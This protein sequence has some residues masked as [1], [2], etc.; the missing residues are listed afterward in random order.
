M[1]T[2]NWGFLF[3]LVILTLIGFTMLYI[4]MQVVYKNQRSGNFQKIMDLCSETYIGYPV[5]VGWVKVY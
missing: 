4:V 3:Y 2:N 1:K 5:S